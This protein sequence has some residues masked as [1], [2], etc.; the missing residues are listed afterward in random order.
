MTIVGCFSIHLKIETENRMENK[1]CLAETHQFRKKK[2]RKNVFMH[3]WGG[4][5]D[6]LQKEYFAKLQQKHFCCIYRSRHM[7]G[8]GSLWCDVA[9]ISRGHIASHNLSKVE[10]AIVKL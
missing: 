5:L 7:L 4:I 9:G 8:T 2:Y 10:R 3:A 1:I 6:D